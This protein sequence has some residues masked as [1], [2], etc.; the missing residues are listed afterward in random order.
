M[1]V[2]YRQ[3]SYSEVLI[4]INFV[5]SCSVLPLSKMTGQQ[6]FYL[7]TGLSLDCMN[8]HLHSLSSIKSKSTLYFIYTIYL[9]YIIYIYIYKKTY[10]YIYIPSSF[11]QFANM[12]S[13][14]LAAEQILPIKDAT[15]PFPWATSQTA[16][17]SSNVKSL[18]NIPT[19][20]TGK[21]K[22]ETVSKSGL[23]HGAL[24]QWR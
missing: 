2:L 9:L 11:Q 21:R 20:E 5:P 17:P 14:I 19:A 18:G 7:L 16:T 10:I 15:Y 4:K 24:V 23:G 6:N 13:Q 8:F 22:F 12:F 1:L 3:N